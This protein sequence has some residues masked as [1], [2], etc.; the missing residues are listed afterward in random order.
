MFD[1]VGITSLATICL[2]VFILSLRFKSFAK[3][4][5]AALIFR[6]LLLLINN[7]IFYLPD[8]DMDGLSFEAFAWQWSQDGFYEVFSHFKGPDTYFLSFLIA[9]PYSLFG[10]S[11]MMAQSFSIFL[12]VLN[13]L[14]VCLIA[15]KLWNNEIAI[16]AGWLAAIFPSAASY[17]VL[18]MRE[19]YIAFFLL[20]AFLHI[21]NF[22]KNKNL[23]SLL[24]IHLSFFGG[25]F[26]HFGSILGLV[27][28]LMVLVFIFINK[29]CHGKVN[30]NYLLIITVAV[31]IFQ[32]SEFKISK[33]FFDLDRTRNKVINVKMMGGA[34]YPEWMKIN[35]NI[36]YLYKAPARMIYFALSPFPWDIKNPRHLLG[37]FDSLFYVFLTFLIFCNL[38]NIKNDKALKVILIVLLAYFFVFGLGVGNFG[39]AIRHRVK[40]VFWMILLAAPLIPKLVLFKEKIIKNKR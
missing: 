40:F 12:G 6:I 14:L 24:F 18:V 22:F 26:F 13:I 1:L 7:N 20:L 36:E 21:L 27:A 2:I 37:L 11:F 31:F 28:F 3:I 8:G 15:R 5:L 4:I 32:F 29:I 17:S 39:T 10:R 19:T 33:E 25:A 38:K 9:I 16:K 23:K 34:V 30:L 35:S